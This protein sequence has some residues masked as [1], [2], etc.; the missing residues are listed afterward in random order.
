M[1]RKNDSKERIINASIRLFSEHG[2]EAVTTRMIANEVGLLP[3][4]L[5]AHFSS[6]EQIL[7]EIYALYEKAL[8]EVLPEMDALI[9]MA[10]TEEP[11]TALMNALHY[12]I[13]ETEEQLD[14]IIALAALDYRHHELSKQFIN[15]VLFD[16]PSYIIRAMLNHMVES[17]RIE[18]IDIDSFLILLTNFVYGYALRKFTDNRIS[19]DEWLGGSEML[20]KLIVVTVI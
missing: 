18:P 15:K 19:F 10:E 20:L 17:N 2:F 8:G 7:T 11:H 1:G 5:Y 12:F 4:S 6:K 16:T 9:E 13:S 3:G 14:R